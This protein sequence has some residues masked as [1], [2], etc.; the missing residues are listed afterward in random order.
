MSD[1]KALINLGDWAQPVNTLIEK[2]A[3]AVGVLYEPKKIIKQAIANAEAD[4]IK[5]INDLE[6]EDLQ[7]RALIRF[8]NE[9]T[10]K[11][12]NIETIIE[13]SIPEISENANPKEID[14][15]W[16]LIYFD[17][18]KFI[19]NDFIQNLW[20]KLLAG[21][22][23]K[24]GSIS[25]KTLN[26]LSE[27]D[28]EDALAFTKLCSFIFYIENE[29]HIFMFDSDNDVYNNYISFD[30]LNNLNTLGL[31]SMNSFLGYMVGD[32]PKQYLM[33]Y[34][35]KKIQVS[36]TNE[37]NNRLDCGKCILTKA[38][39]ELVQFCTPIYEEIIFE[40]TYKHLVNDS[41]LEKIE[42][43]S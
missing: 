43:I 15:D 25:K 17:K 26:I 12:N 35:N 39:R 3:D 18:A 33:I 34:G 28:T 8:I 22:A 9:E 6:I 13:K 42:L 21:E 7:K 30:T 31:I 41:R 14:N 19:S 38:G 11:Q 29:P 40:I 10:I 27:L 1:N 32:F 36:G 20:A 4:K 2:I 37:S 5:A 23:N 16:L 24:P